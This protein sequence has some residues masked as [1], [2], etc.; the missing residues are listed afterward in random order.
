MKNVQ[1]TIPWHEA[2]KAIL[3]EKKWLEKVFKFSEVSRIAEVK[4]FPISLDEMLR[5]ISISI[6]RG[7]IRVKE[8]K[9]KKPNSLW[10]DD[11]T[12]LEQLENTE[13]HG[14]EWHRIMM[15]I[16]IK[17]HFVEN[18]FEVVNEPH[19]NQG[20]S[21]LG[22]YKNGYPNLFVEVGTTSLFKTWINLHTMPQCIFLFVPSEQYAL[23]FQ[24]KLL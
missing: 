3:K 6:V 9:S 21:D 5:Q 22:V 8:L 10:V 24:K 17:N 16:I 15:M 20:R 13:Y 14:S 11:K 1:D 19:L 2:E 4:K 18:G 7:D 12:N 23:E